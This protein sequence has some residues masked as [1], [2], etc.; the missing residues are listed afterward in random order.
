[1][2]F[3]TFL[4]ICEQISVYPR[5]ITSPGFPENYGNYVNV[6]WDLLPDLTG[7]EYLM[8]TLFAFDLEYGYDFLEVSLDFR[9]VCDD[10]PLT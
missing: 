8:A 2:Q 7:A 6:C 4:A 1:M 5:S 10:S 9:E 3:E